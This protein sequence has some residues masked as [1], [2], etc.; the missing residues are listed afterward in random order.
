VHRIARGRR[1]AALRRERP[2]GQARRA[3]GELAPLGAGSQRLEELAG[4]AP[5][6]VLFKRAAARAQHQH[7]VLTRG[8]ARDREQRRLAD[9][10]R[11]FDHD[12]PARARVRGGEPAGKLG[13]LGVAVQQRSHRR[14]PYASP[15]A[16]ARGRERFGRP[17]SSWSLPRCTR[18]GARRASATVSDAKGRR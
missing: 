13:E 7:A 3:D 5:R 15:A 4:D 14:R 12:H 8:V 18:G 16:G 6:G 17:E 11:T 1:L 9:P 2:L 10:G